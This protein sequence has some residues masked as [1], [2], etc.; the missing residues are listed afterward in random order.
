LAV[1]VS[2]AIVPF[3]TTTDSRLGKVLG[4]ENPSSAV[5]IAGFFI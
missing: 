4:E 5:F 2:N 1:F 3:Y